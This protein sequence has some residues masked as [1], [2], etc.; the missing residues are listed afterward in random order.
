MGLGI[1]L[2]HYHSFCGSAEVFT[3]LLHPADVYPSLPVGRG[4][5]MSYVGD[6]RR[7]VAIYATCCDG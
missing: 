6:P 5:V 7:N 1:I 3:S 2:R 4:E